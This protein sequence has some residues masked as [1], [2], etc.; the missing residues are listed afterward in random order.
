MATTIEGV[1]FS[2]QITR[3]LALETWRNNRVVT[4]MLWSAP[5]NPST[6]GPGAVS[7]DWQ[8]NVSGNG[9][10]LVDG[11]AYTGY[12]GPAG[13]TDSNVRDMDGNLPV[14]AI[15]ESVVMYYFLTKS[16][17]TGLPA[18]TRMLSEVGAVPAVPSAADFAA[19]S[20]AKGYLPDRFV[21]V[22][23]LTLNRTGDTTLTQTQDNTWRDF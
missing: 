5:T 3:L 18:L 17:S 19:F 15:G 2:A 14:L 6:Q 22:A 13:F 9:I 20:V 8:V 4:G 7:A 21:R 10:A 11:S 12:Q 1:D 23:K 16:A